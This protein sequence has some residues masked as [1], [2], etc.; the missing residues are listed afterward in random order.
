[1][2]FHARLDHLVQKTLYIRMLNVCAY[3]SHNFLFRQS[4]GKNPLA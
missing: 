4:F 3:L 1:M 2:A